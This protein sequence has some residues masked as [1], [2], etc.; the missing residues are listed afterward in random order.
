MSDRSATI[1]WSPHLLALLAGVYENDN[2]PEEE[3]PT[4]PSPLC[5]LRGLESTIL[6]HVYEYAILFIKDSWMNSIPSIDKICVHNTIPACFI[7]DPEIMDYD[8][9]RR[10]RS[11]CDDTL[12]DA[13]Y[14]RM[15]YHDPLRFRTVPNYMWPEDPEE[16]DIDHTKQMKVIA[17]EDSKVAFTRCGNVTFPS[18]SGIDINMMPFVMGEKSSL[19]DNLQPYYDPL[20][21]KCPISIEEHGKIGYLTITERFIE[22]GSTQRRGGIHI[23][24]P[25]KFVPGTF[26]RNPLNWGE[27]FMNFDI[28][29]GGIYMASNMSS[30]CAIWDALIQKSK[31]MNLTDSR[32]GIDH[33]RPLLNNP[34]FIPANELIWFTDSTPHQAVPQQE[35]GYRQFFR[36]VTG[37][38]NVW[39]SFK[40]HANPKV[41]LP[42]NMVVVEEDE[43]YVPKTSPTRTSRIA[44]FFRR[45]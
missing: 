12:H 19:P 18:P 40:S 43:G 7:A 35:S 2:E 21:A 30:T 16:R 42:S 1:Y 8:M 39:Y 27:G 31:K 3:A 22:K 23:E 28:F 34:Y 25:S 41:P 17:D 45:K 44:K 26:D 11:T 6:K 5:L 32:G 38:V 15:V 33:L 9:V 14:D 10:I 29:E 36:L 13:G 37:D 24:A 20:I 4:K